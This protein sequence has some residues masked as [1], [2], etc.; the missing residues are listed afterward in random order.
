MQERTQNVAVGITTVIGL[1]GLLAMLLLFGYVPEWLEAGYQVRILLPNAAGLSE[2]SRVNL[3]GI[4]IGSVEAVR[5]QE[6]PATGVVVLAR[7]EEDVRLPADARVSVFTPLLGGSPSIQ[8]EVDGIESAQAYLPTDGTAVID[9]QVPTLASEFSRELQAALGEPMAKFDE[10]AASIEA[11]SAEW[12]QVGQNLNQ[13]LEPRTAEAVDAGDAT[14]NIATV[15]ARADERLAE[16]E[17]AL[18]GINR[19]VNDE[20]LRENV[21]VTA[22]NAR[23]LSDTI[24]TSVDELKQTVTENVQALRN[25]YVALA[26]DLSGAVTSMEQFVDQARTGEG[27]LGKLVED[28]DLY[29]NLND[30]A[31][32][33]KQ[34][35]DE[36]RL[37]IQKWKAE[38]VPVQL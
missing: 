32:R 11:L 1:V 7:I 13:L 19:Y 5:L 10:L 3:S 29:Q 23:Q 28:P 14:A 22:A 24:A 9:G 25:R 12:Q 4:D 8:V 2:G 6:P 20:E 31:Q 38:G 17:T 33:M 37:L 18:E 21:R 27:T 35:V 36:L 15:L 26:D 16:M 30:A 34:A